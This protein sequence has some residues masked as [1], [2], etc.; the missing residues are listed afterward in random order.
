MI[1]VGLAA[2]VFIAGDFA[3]PL[4]VFF[5][6]CAKTRVEHNTIR[7]KR[8]TILFTSKKLNDLLKMEFLQM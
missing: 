5:P 7:A 8:L 3:V 1:A 6:A 4:F 2:A